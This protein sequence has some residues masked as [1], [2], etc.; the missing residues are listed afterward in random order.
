M[1]EKYSRCKTLFGDN[2][3]KIQNA[4]ILILGVGGVGGYA[5]DCLYKTG[6]K[7]ITIIDFDIF[8]ASNQ[9]RQIGSE[10]LGENKVDVLKRL[11]PGINTINQKIT[12]EWLQEN[13]LSSFDLIIDAIDDIKPKI[14]LIRRY[15]KNIIT[16]TGSAKRIDPSKIEYINIWDTQNDS[17]AK[18]IKY[19]LKKINF[20]KKLKVVTSKEAANCKDLG[21]FIGVTASF[22]LMMC[23]I[24]IEK[25]IKRQ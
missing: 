17:F 20:N 10:Y 11:Y 9:N 12:Y 25:I 8:E 19:E 15:Y 7:Y 13:D 6:V 5:L 16:T 21:S 4:K 1:E 23:S 22:G 24:A 2:F 18:K 3:Q 14:E